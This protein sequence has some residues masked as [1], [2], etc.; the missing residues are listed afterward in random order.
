[1]FIMGFTLENP[2]IK[3]FSKICGVLPVDQL[4]FE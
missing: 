4:T 3:V 1:M 2:V